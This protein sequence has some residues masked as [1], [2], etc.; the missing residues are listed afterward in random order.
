MISNKGEVFGMMEKVW[1]GGGLWYDGKGGVGGWEVISNKGEVFGVM[2]KV[3][4]SG[5]K[6]GV[7][8]SMMGKVWKKLC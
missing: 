3:W 6:T 4:K 7:M 1:K 8:F 2:E 5:L